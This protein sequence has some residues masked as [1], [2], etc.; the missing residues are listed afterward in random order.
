MGED[1]S[2]STEGSSKD[3]SGDEGDGASYDGGVSRRLMSSL[4]SLS[5]SPHIVVSWSIW[6]VGRWALVTRMRLGR[7]LLQR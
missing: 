1:G 7:W 3:D 6:L 5:S 4:P 2:G